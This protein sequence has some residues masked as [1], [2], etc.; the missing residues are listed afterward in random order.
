MGNFGFLLLN[1]LKKFKNYIL[2]IKRKPWKL[3]IYIFYISWFGF[4]LY[5]AFDQDIEMTQIPNLQLKQNVFSVIIRLLV[6]LLFAYILY[7]SSKKFDGGFSMGDVNFLFPSPTSPKTILA[8]SMLKQSFISIISSI[9]FIFLLPMLQNIFGNIDP[10]DLIVSLIGIIT[11]FIFTVPFSYLTFILSSRFGLG[12]WLKYF[13]YGIGIFV[14]GIA[15]YGISAHQDFLEGVF[16]AFN[17]RAFSYIPIVGWSS[18]LIGV[19]V[20]GKTPLSIIALFLQLF[21]ISIFSFFAIFL[22][23]DYY[24]DALPSAE[25]RAQAVRASKEGK[26]FSLSDTRSNKKVRQ[27]N[28]RKVGYGPWAFLW[29]Q[30]VSNKR[31]SGSLILQWKTLGALVISI[32]AGMLIPQKSSSTFYGIAGGI[33]YLIFLSSTDVSIEYELNMR[34]IF[35][36]PGQSWK[37]ILA[38]NIVPIIKTIIFLICLLFPVGLIFQVPIFSLL[39]GLLFPISMGIL[40]LFSSV[41]MHILIPSGFD[42]KVFYPVLRIFGFLLFLIPPGVLGIVVGGYTNSVALGFYT[43]AILNLLLSIL[44]LWITDKAFGRL[45]VR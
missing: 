38:L 25:Q 18:E 20:F 43:V 14:L 17:H 4:I 26:R 13:L 1:D 11:L 12:E 3:L 42:R 22:A 40:N 6:F 21:T 41:I 34:Y 28:V 8:Y 30:L 36:L 19:V 33:A 10:G 2:E 39:A 24:E 31:A 37:K 29:M 16:W 44:F 5:T 45:E 9:F 23:K 27:V 15:A 7:S 35:V 32:G